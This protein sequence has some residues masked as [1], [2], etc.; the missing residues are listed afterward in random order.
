MIYLALNFRKE[1]RFTKLFNPPEVQPLQL[2]IFNSDNLAN[3]RFESLP[4]ISKSEL[5]ILEL[6]ISKI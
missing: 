6:E 4:N 1:L 3:Y 5:Q 2:S